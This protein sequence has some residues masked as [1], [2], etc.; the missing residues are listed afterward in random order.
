MRAV[1][2]VAGLLAMTGGC[3]EVAFAQ[4]SVRRASVPLTRLRGG[5]VAFSTYSG[6]IDSTRA[7]VRDSVRWRLLW[8]RLNKPFYPRPALPP[9]DFQREMV[10]VAALGAKPSGGYGLLIQSAEQDSIGIEGA[11]RRRNPAPRRPGAPLDT[12]TAQPRPHPG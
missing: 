11:L 1:P 10:V 5:P 12:P 8:E 2:L 9:I 7:V 4:P 6:L 3:I